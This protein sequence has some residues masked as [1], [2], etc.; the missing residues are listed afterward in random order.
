MTTTE[1]TETTGTTATDLQ[2]PV[3]APCWMDLVSSDPDAS[4]AF[5]TAL[6]G[7]TVREAPPHLRGY[8]YFELDGRGVGGVMTNEAA[9]GM[10]DAWSVF[11]RTDDVAAT[12]AAARA[13]GGSVLMEPMEVPPNGSFVIVRDTGGAVVSGWQPG[14]ES[15][16]GV[17]YQAGSPTHFELHTRAFDAAVSFYRSVFGWGDH[18]IDAPG[19]RYA[20]YADMS[21]PRAGIM[22]DSAPGLPEE[23]PRWAV[24]FGADDADTTVQ[25]AVT[26]GATVLMAPEDT[27]YGRLAVLRDPTGA[28]FR[29]QS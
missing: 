5:Y 7:W 16:F 17:L 2:I 8:R 23:E 9:W 18:L 3:G 4:V 15:G 13:H 12:A 14:T 27:P 1:T 28:E 10:P 29:L 22:D 11:L 25:R 6:F 24:Y 19:F 26:L 20:T 21:E